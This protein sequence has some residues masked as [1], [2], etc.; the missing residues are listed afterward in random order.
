M[1]MDPLLQDGDSRNMNGTNLSYK[2]R[3]LCQ[4]VDSTHTTPIQCLQLIHNTRDSFPNLA[5]ALNII[6][7]APTA[8]AT[9][10]EVFKSYK[11]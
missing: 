10:E 9:A 3:I 6:L 7:T 11:S 5:V 1:D 8:A 4:I 2:I